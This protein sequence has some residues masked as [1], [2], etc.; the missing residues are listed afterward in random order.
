MTSLLCGHCLL[1][2]RSYLPEPE[3]GLEHA[4]VLLIWQTKHNKWVKWQN[5]QGARFAKTT[6]NCSNFFLTFS[7]CHNINMKL[8]FLYS[9]VNKV[10]VLKLL[11]FDAWNLSLCSKVHY[12]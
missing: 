6:A 2:N 11:L 4:F 7:E 1:A 12:L 3:I 9:K 10:M 8:V 5:L